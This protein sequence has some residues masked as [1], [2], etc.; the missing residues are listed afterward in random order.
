[1]SPEI[2]WH[3]RF[4]QQAEWTAALRK[5]L[6]KQ[7]DLAH[8]SR[9]LEVG[10]GTGAILS[11]LP[12]FTQAEIQGL[13]LSRSRLAEASVHA[14]NATFT[15]GNA[16]ALPYH[17]H[18]FDVVFCHFLLLWVKEPVQS[19]VEMRRVT[20]PGG[21]VLL[22]AEPDYS[23]RIDQP[24]EMKYLGELQTLSLIQQGADP[25]MGCKLKDLMNESGI[26]LVESGVLKPKPR[27]QWDPQ[28]WEMEW[29]V[30]ESDLVGSIPESKLASLKQAD[31]Q[32][33]MNGTRVML[34]PT[35]FAWGRV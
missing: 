4:T 6:Y 2:K 29:E 26:N 25:V 33:W 18:S 3:E 32:A 7:A 11:E 34:V 24:K 13:D 9:I 21:A 16:I 5:Y 23:H 15:Q 10:C 12:N 35:Y 30:L 8:S 31:L 20:H 1:M 27:N 17:S 14:K 28:A 22:M 19:L